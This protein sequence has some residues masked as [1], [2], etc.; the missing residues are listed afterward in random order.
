M[1]DII[2]TILNY[3]ASASSVAGFIVVAKFLIKKFGDLGQ[4][5]MHLGFI[6]KALQESLDRNVKLEKELKD[7]QMQLK[8]FRVHGKESIKKN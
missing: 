5:K 6:C 3:V 2:Y 4:I 1:N 7:L 8:G